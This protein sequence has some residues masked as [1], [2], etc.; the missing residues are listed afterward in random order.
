[1]E[2]SI[3]ERGIADD[4]QIVVADSFVDHSAARRVDRCC[5]PVGACQTRQQLFTLLRAPEP[6]DLPHHRYC[7]VEVTRVHDPDTAEAA[8]S[9]PVSSPVSAGPKSTTRSADG[10]AR[11]LSA[12]LLD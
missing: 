8:R 5:Q 9:S 12:A 3:G 2:E 4:C 7:E 10:L 11:C 6:S 1:M